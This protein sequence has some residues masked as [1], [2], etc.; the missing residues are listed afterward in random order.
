MPAG[1]PFNRQDQFESKD[2]FLWTSFYLAGS[3]H[4]GVGGQGQRIQKKTLTVFSWPDPMPSTMEEL[5][6]IKDACLCKAHRR[7]CLNDPS[8]FFFSGLL[9]KSSNHFLSR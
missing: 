9:K 5:L 2:F 8:L 1:S 3:F 7:D 6:F 4:S